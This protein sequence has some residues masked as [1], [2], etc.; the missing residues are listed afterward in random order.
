MWTNRLLKILF[1]HE[2]FPSQFTRLGVELNRQGDFECYALASSQCLTEAAQ[3]IGLPHFGFEPDTYLQRDKELPT[4]YRPVQVLE[5]IMRNTYGIQ[6]AVEKLCL[7]HHFDAVIGHAGFGATAGLRRILPPSTALLAYA[8]LPG[9]EARESRPEFP[10]D[11]EEHL[12]RFALQSV[13]YT[14][15]LEADLAIVPSLHARSFYPPELQPRIRTQIE[16]FNLKEYPADR[17]ALG[18]P[19]AGKLVG[20]FGQTLE[21]TRGFDI[22]VQVAR[23]LKENDDSLQFLVIGRDA[24]Y[25]GNEAGYLQGESFKSYALRQA[26]VSEEMFIWREVLPYSQFRKHLACLDLAILPYFGGAGNWSFF[27]AM[28]SGVP[29]VASNRAFLPEYAEDCR[30]AFLCDPA[31]VDLQ[32]RR[33]LELL[34]NPAKAKAFGAAARARARR[35]FDIAVVAKNYGELVKEAVRLRPQSDS[36]QWVATARKRGKPTGEIHIHAVT[37]G[38]VCDRV[39]ILE[40]MAMLATIPGV[41]CTANRKWPIRFERMPQIVIEQR[42]RELSLVAQRE[43]LSRGAL[44]LAEIDDDPEGLE[45]L[46]AE[47]FMPIRAVHAVQVSTARLAET[48]RKWN[49]HVVVFENRIAALP[50]WE[51]KEDSG[52]VRIFYGALNRENDWKTIVPALNRVLNEHGDKVMVQVVQDQAF[53]EAL[54]TPYKQFDPFCPWPNYRS[55]LRRCDIA[56]LPLAANRFNE[57]KSN[58]KFLECAAEGVAVLASDTVYGDTIAAGRTGLLYHEDPATSFADCLAQLLGSRALRQTLAVNA[59]AYVRDHCL[60]NRHFRKRHAW[61][62]DLL[63]RKPELDRDLFDRVPELA[64]PH[65]PK[66]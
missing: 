44:V 50:P 48:V 66:G 40:P 55:L 35:E 32:V 2:G 25:H 19:A 34:Q 10:L 46:S 9:V 58:L 43:L 33:S 51:E 37:E 49:P 14:S 15:F 5:R 27:D 42:F 63:S 21:S 65:K 61:Y 53:Y 24:T 28:C 56:L 4:D 41:R 29:L 17:T 11:R 18:L 54:D 38:T 13:V 64:R 62:L 60:L 45:G 52:V 26:G 16:G 22:F 1:I 31:D 30:E 59:Y 36:K 3:R 8:E 7:T 47:S 20:F 6:Q 12:E 23:R 57:H 39:R